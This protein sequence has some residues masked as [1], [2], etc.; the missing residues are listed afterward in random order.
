M[1]PKPRS[2]PPGRWCPWRLSRPR[3]SRCP[4][5]PPSSSPGCS[6]SQRWRAKPRRPARPGEAEQPSPPAP[7]PRRAR[8][9]GQGPGP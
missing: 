3:S 2:G 8:P 9:L 1:R 6:T 7:P 4:W 5:L